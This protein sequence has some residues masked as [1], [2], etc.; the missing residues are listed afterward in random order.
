MKPGVQRDSE[1]SIPLVTMLDIPFCVWENSAVWCGCPV[2]N[3]SYPKSE[4][5]SNDIYFS[6]LDSYWYGYL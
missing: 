5:L 1:R 3:I 2:G 4:Y 6:T